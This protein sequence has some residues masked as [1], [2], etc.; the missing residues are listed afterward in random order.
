MARLNNKGFSLVE[1]VVAVAVFAILIV[2]LTTQLI[3]A[4][5]TNK[6]TNIKQQE[7]EVAEEFMESFKA[8]D[9][10]KSSIVVSD[11]KPSSSQEYV[12]TKGT[13]ASATLSLPGGETVDYEVT[14]YNCNNIKT[15]FNTYNCEITVDNAAYAALSKGYVY[16]TDG[17]LKKNDYGKAATGTIR[18]LDNNQSAIIAGATYAGSESALTQKNLDYGAY[19]YFQETKASLLVNYPVYYSQYLSGRNYF[20][21][22]SFK[23]YTTIKISKTVA[24]KYKVECIVKYE[25]ITGVSFIS[26]E[27][28]AD[29]KNIYYP[30]TKDGNGIVYSKEFDEEVPIYLLYL[31]AICNGKYVANDYIEI[32]NSGAPDIEPKVYIFE[33]AAS[34]IDA[35]YK[36]IIESQLGDFNDLVYTSPEDAVSYKNVKVS[37]NSAGGDSDKLKVYANFPTD[38]ASSDILVK[39]MTEDESDNVYMYSIKVTLTD[40]DGKKTEIAGTRGK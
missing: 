31:P 13:P 22:D 35:K 20:E 32:D 18:N 6:K 11:G 9:L 33:T 26:S 2:P 4:V 12:F 21:N 17:N 1:V 38:T 39:P 28:T 5:K 7:I 30:S 23:K 25:D 14:K 37:V 34:N 29:N 40:Q 10:N 24:D 8:C 15:A 19:E 16:D 3:A 27:Y 36:Q